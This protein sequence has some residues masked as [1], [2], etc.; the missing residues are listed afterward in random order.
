VVDLVVV[1]DWMAPVAVVQVVGA[2][3][4]EVVVAFP[5]GVM[6]DSKIAALSSAEPE[7]SAMAYPFG[8]MENWGVVVE[9]RYFHPL[10]VVMMSFHVLVLVPKFKTV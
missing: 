9:I 8:G 3:R 2:A 5:L 1:E 10:V 6:E 4:L 7:N